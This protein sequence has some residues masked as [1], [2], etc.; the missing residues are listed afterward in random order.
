MRSLHNLSTNQNVSNVVSAH[1]I[2][3]HSNDRR[4]DLSSLQR[5]HFAEEASTEEK[6][7]SILYSLG[8]QALPSAAPAVQT[9]LTHFFTP[10]AAKSRAKSRKELS[11]QTA[12]KGTPYHGLNVSAKNQYDNLSAAEIKEQLRCC[13][14]LLGRP[15]TVQRLPDRG[16]RIK[17]KMEQ[18]DEALIRVTA[19]SIIRE[20]NEKHRVADDGLRQRLNF[21]DS[22][23][24][25]K[26]DAAPNPKL[27]AIHRRMM[28]SAAQIP[29]G[30]AKNLSEN[31]LKDILNSIESMTINPLDAVAPQQSGSGRTE[32]RIKNLTATLYPH[33]I[34]GVQWMIG[35]ETHSAD[36][37]PFGGIIA[38]EM[39]LG[40]TMQMIA[41]MLHRHDIPQRV[42]PPSKQK[43]EFLKSSSTLIVCP[44]SV[45]NHWHSEIQ[46]HTKRGKLVATKY[47]GNGRCKDVERLTA[48]FNVIITT[49]GCVQSEWTVWR[50]KEDQRIAEIKDVRKQITLLQRYHLRAGDVHRPEH[51][52][53]H[54]ALKMRLAA[55]AK[56]R[57]TKPILSQIMYSRVVLDEA[58]QIKNWKSK[59]HRAICD[60]RGRAHWFMTAT[61]IQNTLDDLYAAF[62]FLRYQHW[63]NY[64]H[65][66]AGILNHSKGIQRI[67][68]LLAG[69][70]LR[71]LKADYIS[72][73]SAE[74]KHEGDDEAATGGD[75]RDRDLRD[76]GR[77]AG[78][79]AAAPKA[80]QKMIHLPPKVFVTHSVKFSD[81]ERFIYQQLK[82]LMNQIFSGYQ[83]TNSVGKHF[84]QCLKMLLQL[85]QSCNHLKLIK[86]SVHRIHSILD[87]L[88]KETNNMDIEQLLSVING[89]R[90][91][92]NRGALQCSQQYLDEIKNALES[93]NDECPICLDLI[94]NVSITVCGHRF[95]TECLRD[96]M[97]ER[98]QELRRKR[99]VVTAKQFTVECPVC[100]KKL[101]RSQITKVVDEEKQR[102]L[103]G[104]QKFKQ[105]R[106][107]RL[108]ESSSKIKKLMEILEEI[109]DTEPAAKCIVFSQ[110]TSMLDIIEDELEE[111]QWGHCRLDGKM[112][113]NNR[114]KS[115][116]RLNTDPSCWVMLISL[117]AGGVGLNLVAANH[118]FM[119]DIWWNP[120]IEDQAMDRVHRIGQTKTVTMHRIVV[121]D[122]VEQRVLELQEKKRGI[123]EKALD[124]KGG[125]KNRKKQSVNFSARD[126]I[127]LFQDART[128]QAQRNRR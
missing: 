68:T 63:S 111:E 85:R 14:E 71:R 51:V 19:R 76:D 16:K 31:N 67:R 104:K 97:D 34:A 36:D 109:H 119:M 122:T 58:H 90:S 1:P 92:Q 57:F 103:G 41:L 3:S 84:S 39:G 23:P 80:K 77:E 55:A 56:K 35:R 108:N 62:H 44:V 87:G 25:R 102:E 73:A 72:S 89:K 43:R 52:A 123:A 50:K 116:H 106:N 46:K 98:E 21:A 113:S 30:L 88:D 112:T 114:S 91:C 101:R 99:K 2:D 93:G 7:S 79:R 53:Q 86:N 61:P 110:W 11:P 6:A 83:R 74:H 100:R 120:A 27:N 29:R 105:R 70:M 54:K 47:H 10:H 28:G 49:Y 5:P 40:K 37:Q 38:D 69:V 115:I 64:N 107:D 82:T 45:L 32:L 15:Q 78:E 9:K 127:D 117:K 18:L 59:T 12:L 17:R 20:Q 95:C 75:A 24:V 125:S 128:G 126:L 42:D 4:H 118:V 94:E 65:W 26:E 8:S 13:Q 33:Q 96:I 81:Y 60:L 48:N 121:D 66:K 124:M 22:N